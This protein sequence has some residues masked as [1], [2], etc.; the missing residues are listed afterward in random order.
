MASNKY[1]AARFPAY[2][3]EHPH[4]WRY[5]KQF[6]LELIGAGHKQLGHG[7]IFGRIRY[8]SFLRKHARDRFKVNQNF[9]KYYAEKFVKEFPQYDNVF[10]FRTFRG[11][12]IYDDTAHLSGD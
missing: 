1:W 2:D 10:S 3:A 7:L 8:E 11:R 5:F 6:T 4:V 12:E 9:A